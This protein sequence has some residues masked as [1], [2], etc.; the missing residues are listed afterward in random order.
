MEKWFNK[1]SLNKPDLVFKKV[2]DR[3]PHLAMGE[4]ASNITNALYAIFC[5]HY[6]SS[7]S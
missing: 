5:H 1:D 2:N 6:K 7:Y 4:F 3:F